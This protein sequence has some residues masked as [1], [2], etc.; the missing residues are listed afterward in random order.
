MVAISDRSGR[1]RIDDGQQRLGDGPCT[2]EGVADGR[3]VA[4]M[5]HFDADHH[6]GERGRAS[7][8]FSAEAEPSADRRIRIID[9]QPALWRLARIAKSRS[10]LS[11]GVGGGEVRGEESLAVSRQPQLVQPAVDRGAAPPGPCRPGAAGRRDQ[12]TGTSTGNSAPVDPPI[13]S[14]GWRSREPIRPIRTSSPS[15]TAPPIPAP[16]PDL[17]ERQP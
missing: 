14:G 6:A 9:H 7:W 11:G 17:R 10:D 13:A 15:I 3:R 4:A 16:P 1:C 8:S 2:A 5:P 12:T